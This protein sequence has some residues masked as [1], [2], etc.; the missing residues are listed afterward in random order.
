MDESKKGR[1]KDELEKLE[2]MRDELRLH[3]HLF[4]ADM[5][6]EWEGLEKKLEGIRRELRPVQEAAEQTLDEIGEA[7]GLLIDSV[8][9]GFKRL[10]DSIK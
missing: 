2:Q 1:L 7:T 9:D 3:A 5:K 10:R 8:F 4:K 6:D